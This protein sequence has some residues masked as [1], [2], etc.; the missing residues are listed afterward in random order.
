MINSF[1][2]RMRLGSENP[3]VRMAA[4]VK[5][6]STDQEVI[7]EIAADDPDPG[8]RQEAANRLDDPAMLEVLWE[9]EKDEDMK[10]SLRTRLNRRYIAMLTEGKK[11]KDQYLRRIDDELLLIT[12][13]CNTPD[14]EISAEVAALVKSDSGILTILR[15]LNNYEL[16]VKLFDSLGEQIEIWHDLAESAASPQLKEYIQ[17]K[18]EAWESGNE[19]GEE[20]V[21][22][23]PGSGGISQALKEKLHVYEGIINEVKRLTGYIGGDA[24]ERLNGLKEKWASLPMVSPSFMEVLEIEFKQACDN[25]AAGIETARSLQLERLQRID[26]LD[27]IYTE[28]LRLVSDPE[29]RLKKEMVAR[30]QKNWEE[31]AEGITAIEP[32]QERFVRIC[33]ELEQ[34]LQTSQEELTASISRMEEIVSE[35]TVQEAMAE[36]DMPKEKRIELEQE[37]DELLAKTHDNH[38]AR[39]LKARFLS[40]N[41]H[42][43]Q[44]IHEIH[45]VR[46]L[47]R[48]EN[49]AL[50]IVICEQAEKLLEE[51][52]IHE[53]SKTF[54]D[55]RNRW[56]D[57][58][59]V[60]HEKLEE[61]NTRFHTVADELTRRCSEFFTELNKKREGIAAA[62]EKL[63]AEAEALQESQEWNKTADRYK[64]MQKE[65]RELGLAQPEVEKTL[66]KRFRDACDIFFN[67]RRKFLDELQTRRKGSQEEKLALCE[68]VETLL[69]ENPAELNRKSRQYWDRWREAG[70][71]G[72]DDHKLYER[73]K[74]AFDTY[75]DRLRGERENNLE[76]KKQICQSLKELLDSLDIAKQE[77]QQ[78]TF[79]DLQ[80]EW[81]TAGPV[82]KENDKE[83]WREYDCVS[84]DLQHRFQENQANYAVHLIDIQE[85]LCQLIAGMAESK[86]I[87]ELGMIPAELSGLRKI[88]ED[89][90][91]AIRDDNQQY[92]DNF[93]SAQDTS[94]KEMQ[95]ICGELEKINGVSKDT[96]GDTLNA[97]LADLNAALQNNIGSPGHDDGRRKQREVKDLQQQWQKVGVPRANEIAALFKRYREA[98][99]TRNQ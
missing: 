34:K 66:T 18:I 53:V 89:M 29:V 49:Y 88:H 59:S 86:S 93:R 2:L 54:K 36:P 56:K 70:S 75:Y 33:A 69:Q 65:W 68:E 97:M 92:F 30:I 23:Q 46:D 13:V 6:P 74:A 24:T 72:R 95:R 80:R 73:F 7:F 77:E 3:E 57:I 90:V 87:E 20:T 52:N 15:N 27:E 25:F 94:L 32:L 78:R 48:W 61:I 91:A 96:G 64:A 84:R 44:K 37:I 50:K 4:L 81:D 76:K 43:R 45:Q 85:K 99:R 58:G 39:R 71:A 51:T 67:G 63:C 82:P 31:V 40:L 16:G 5:I 17:R 35:I 98:V 14:P 8:I 83:I 26:K 9:R 41:K 11:V 42:L 19:E 28:A 12:A 21:D 38:Q 1:W 55:L 79:R 62:K 22:Q 10:R 60:P 47:A